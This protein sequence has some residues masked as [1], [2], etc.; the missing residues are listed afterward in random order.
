LKASSPTRFVRR[1]PSRNR[2]HP[3][4]RPRGVAAVLVCLALAPISVLGSRADA[5]APRDQHSFA[6]P[7]QARV[8]HIA[9][10]VT[11]DFTT[12]T[13]DGTATLTFKAVDGA[14][15]LI[16]D[17]SDLSIQGVSAPD[18]RVLRYALGNKNAVIGQALTIEL[19]PGLTT[20][21][22]HYKTSPTAGALQWLSPAQTAGKQH[23]YMFSQGQAILTRSWIP[24][25]DSP[26]I[27]Q[28]Y[29][30]RV[31]VPRGLRA[32]MS[33]EQVE[34]GDT[35]RGR[36]FVFRQEHPIPPY[37]IALAVG[38]I[39]FTPVGSP[40]S[41]CGGQAQSA[42]ATVPD[43]GNRAGARTGVYAEP[44]VLGRAAYE[45]ADLEKMLEA[46]ESL[47]GKYR[48]GRYDILVMPPSFPYGG[49]ENPRLTFA[50]PTALA[51]DRSLTSLAAH[52]M[53]HSW[54]GNLVTNA[55]WRDFW[56][57]EGF[58]TYFE[59]RIMEALYGRERAAMLEQVGRSDLLES[60][61]ALPPNDTVLY[62]DLTGRAPDEGGT[63]VPYEKGFAFLR[64]LERAFGRDV[65]DAWLR[66]YFDRFAFQSITTPQFLAYLRDTLL[67]SD[68][69]A[70]ARLR[71]DEWLFKPGLPA[72]APAIESEAFARV[73]T[74]ARAFASGGP[75]SAL[76]VSNWSTQE[77]QHFLTSLP[78]TL[79][80]EQLDDLDRTFNLSEKANSEVRFLWLRMAVTHQYDPAVPAVEGFLKAQGR[81]KFVTPLYAALAK[82]GWGRPI[83][84]RVYATARPTYH[85]TAQ[86][87]I[88]K[89]LVR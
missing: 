20:L 81:L 88:D 67:R 36:T 56:L 63:P 75:A 17:T 12:K 59:N 5:T 43:Q 47:Y 8:T 83:A 77:W 11:A 6:D 76:R 55:T 19:A 44:A 9:L 10:D 34:A 4:G 51:G 86:K 64:M 78:E 29:S 80:R 54:S 57:N 31:T 28:T 14:R 45:F 30:A 38:D 68:R 41:R 35:P 1:D 37:L 87:A 3:R 2:H 23:P 71:V 26:G 89:L 32:V 73:D 50:T 58:T 52:E 48:W 49:M 16:L 66:R 42:A 82:T 60:L 61:K 84:E 62:V 13:L 24:T 65:F 46:A 18:G 15:A 33:A 74:Q 72:N 85:P 70:E 21:T 69:E 39:A 40:F 79:T 22:V 27:R 25:Q 53:A 7:E